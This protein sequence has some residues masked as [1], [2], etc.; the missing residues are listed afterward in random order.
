MY[1]LFPSK[2]MPGSPDPGVSENDPEE[3]DGL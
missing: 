3:K 1:I 2:K